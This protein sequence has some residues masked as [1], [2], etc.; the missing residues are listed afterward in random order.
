MVVVRKGGLTPKIVR[1]E[2]ERE[3]HLFN[4]DSAPDIQGEDQLSPN[5]NATAQD[6]QKDPN[7]ES[8]IIMPENQSKELFEEQIQEIDQ[9]LCKFDVNKESFLEKQWGYNK[10]NIL[11]ALTINEGGSSTKVHSRAH[12]SS[13]LNRAT[14]AIIAEPTSSPELNIRR[15]KQ[16]TR[17][18]TKS[19]IVMEEAMGEKR[20]GREEDQ[21]DLQKRRKLVSWVGEEIIDMSAEAGSQPCRNQ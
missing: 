9:E 19:D 10:E 15:W 7:E 14:A 8:P 17:A 20:S 4:A 21:S 11:E 18:E 6:F 13:I 12:P 3:E 5:S 1:P 2:K 16:V